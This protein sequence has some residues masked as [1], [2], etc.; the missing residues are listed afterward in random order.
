MISE[1]VLV[2]FQTIEFEEFTIGFISRD[3]TKRIDKLDDAKEERGPLPR[4]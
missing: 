3:L 4:V 1:R 2:L